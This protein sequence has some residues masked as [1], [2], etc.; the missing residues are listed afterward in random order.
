MSLN[1]AAFGVPPG[2]LKS[3]PKADTPLVVRAARPESSKPDKSGHL[4][5][6]RA[7]RSTS[8]GSQTGQIRT[9]GEPPGLQT[10]ADKSGHLPMTTAC[11]RNQT[12]HR[13]DIPVASKTGQKRTDYIYS[14]SSSWNS[15]FGHQVK[16]FLFRPLPIW[17]QREM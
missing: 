11:P 6:I 13:T 7:D 3:R 14:P 17:P 16:D 4:P 9:P 8:V 12:G 2:V 1:H 15:A 10:G 5:M